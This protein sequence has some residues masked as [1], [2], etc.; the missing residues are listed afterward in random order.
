MKKFILIVSFVFF[1]GPVTAFSGEIQGRPGMGSYECQGRA[2][3]LVQKGTFPPSQPNIQ[4][5]TSN[6]NKSGTT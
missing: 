5:N 3:E 2:N 4:R 6:A 1:L